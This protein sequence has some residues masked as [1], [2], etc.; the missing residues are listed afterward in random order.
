MRSLG[1]AKETKLGEAGNRS[2]LLAHIYVYIYICCV[3]VICSGNVQESYQKDK[4]K[5]G[6]GERDSLPQKIC[7]ELGVERE[8]E[9]YS[10]GC[11]ESGKL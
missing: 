7:R 9:G 4:Y 11:K 1:H 3:K 2:G 10:V 8:R 5:C 6:D